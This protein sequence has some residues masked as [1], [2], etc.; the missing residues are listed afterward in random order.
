[1]LWTCQRNG[2][3]G[4]VRNSDPQVVQLDYRDSMVKQ[5]RMLVQR[6]TTSF[7]FPLNPSDVVGFP[8]GAPQDNMLLNVANGIWEDV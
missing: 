7:E 4:I 6:A 1:M 5:F 2:N 8:G 3:V